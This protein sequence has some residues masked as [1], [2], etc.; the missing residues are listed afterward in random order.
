MFCNTGLEI[1][2][3][4]ENFTTAKKYVEVERIFKEQIQSYSM[5]LIPQRKQISC[6]MPC[7]KDDLHR[8]RFRRILQIYCL[9]V[10]LFGADGTMS[11]RKFPIIW[12]LIFAGDSNISAIT[13]THAKYQMLTMMFSNGVI[14]EQWSFT[15]LKLELMGSTSLFWVWK[16]DLLFRCPS[17]WDKGIFEYHQKGIDDIKI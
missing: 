1:E 8:N 11:P 14:S 7:P 6:S 9:T 5:V 2:S 17:Q 12:V 4:R 16:S 15:V 13:S 10:K 3:G